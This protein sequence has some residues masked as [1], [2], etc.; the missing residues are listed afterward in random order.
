MAAPPVIAW[1]SSPGGN[2]RDRDAVLRLHRMRFVDKRGVDAAQELIE[3]RR[4]DVH[5]AD[6]QLQKKHR[7]WLQGVAAMQEEAL[8]R[9][10]QQGSMSNRSKDERA[11]MEEKRQDP[12][13]ARA[14]MAEHTRNQ[15]RSYREAKEAMAEAVKAREAL[16]VRTR[17]EIQRLERPAEQVEE[18]QSKVVR[19]LR[20]NTRKDRDW[21]AA[22]NEKLQAM[23]KMS[24][25]NKAERERMEEI[26]QGTNEVTEQKARSA[27]EHCRTWKEEKAAMT[28]RLET[29]PAMSFRTREELEQDEEQRKH[30]DEA[31]DRLAGGVKDRDKAYKGEIAA[32]AERVQASPRKTFWTHEQRQQIEEARRDPD[33]ARQR[34]AKQM[35]ELAQNYKKQR[36][37]I[38]ERVRMLPR[39][40]FLSPE[41]RERREAVDEIR[42]GRAHHATGAAA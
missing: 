5:K 29:I 33:E 8:K 39:K 21:K 16:N 23:P 12:E 27:R 13:E 41:V 42:R 31:R 36:D 10:R 26:H 30:L 6:A 18:A 9:A 1:S 22:T 34:M 20:E 24:F 3:E 37:G 14:K 19:Q 40:T 35:R 28:A 38:E 32:L 25:W 17:G 11:R 2:V 7:E 4:K 15:V